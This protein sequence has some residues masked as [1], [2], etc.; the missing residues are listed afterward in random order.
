[1]VVDHK[2]KAVYK[3]GD[4][5]SLKEVL[6]YPQKKQVIDNNNKEIILKTL[7]SLLEVNNKSTMREVNK[8]LWHKFGVNIYSD[9]FICDK[10]KRVIAQVNQKI[11]D[12]LNYNAKVH[13]IKGF[14]PS[15][16]QER[17]I[18]CQFGH[19]DNEEDIE[20]TPKT[21]KEKTNAVINNIKE[22]IDTSDKDEIYKNLKA[23]KIIIIRKE[24]ELYALDMGTSTIVNLH[25]TDIVLSKLKVYNNRHS[26]QKE[27]Q[28]KIPGQWVKILSSTSS[29][30]HSNREWEVGGNSDWDNVDDDRKFRR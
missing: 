14:N 21:N 13:W 27:N 4:V 12:T 2:E 9:G 7:N 6:T 11:L 29:A 18:L 28:V 17:A 8:S 1:M 24:Q 25:E 22:I 15:T 20:I 19:I 26:N 23:A 3:G 5:L 10:Q 30:H 16:M